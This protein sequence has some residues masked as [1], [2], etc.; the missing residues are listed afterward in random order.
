M[1]WHVLD[2][3]PM[4]TAKRTHS[5]AILLLLIPVGA[6]VYAFS[7]RLFL[8]ADHARLMQTAGLASLSGYLLV[9]AC[10]MG[11]PQRNRVD[12]P[13]FVF[14]LMLWLIAGV[15]GVAAINQRADGQASSSHHAAVTRT[16]SSSGGAKAGGGG[17]TLWLAPNSAGLEV[18]HVRKDY[19]PLVQ[20]GADGLEFTL[21]PGFLGMPWT[22]EYSVI[23]DYARWKAQ[24]GR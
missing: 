23:R 9:W 4:S 6:L 14:L 8:P 17:C 7:D 3:D 15:A 21:A 22:R 20:P 11:R 10:T 12:V 16:H 2:V 5:G 13:L 1:A 24:P 18:L 19:C